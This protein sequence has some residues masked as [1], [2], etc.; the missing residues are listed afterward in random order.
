VSL[1]IFRIY[2]PAN[3]EAVIAV[4]SIVSWLFI[5]KSEKWLFLVSAGKD[6][7]IVK[8]TNG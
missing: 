8:L 2:C 7:E 1:Y 4:L 5:L 3:L 6:K